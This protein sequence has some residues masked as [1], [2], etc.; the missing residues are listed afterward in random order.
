MWFC[1]LSEHS[2]PNTSW[3]AKNLLSSQT[4]YTACNRN[5]VWHQPTMTHSNN[6]EVAITYLEPRLWYY[7]QLA[8]IE[9]EHNNICTFIIQWGT[10]VLVLINIYPY[11]H[12]NTARGMRA[13]HKLV[14]LL[15]LLDH[16]SSCR[17]FS[18]RVVF[19]TTNPHEP[20]LIFH[21]NP[22]WWL[23]TFWL[24]SKWDSKSS[25]R[26]AKAKFLVQV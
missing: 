3:P 10:P 18:T 19:R 20:L 15:V 8:H 4:C 5:C 11:I 13:K 2:Q 23:C 17:G 21:E 16:K 9:T 26:G 6:S 1:K 24:S 7:Q 25:I 12:T 22:F 14:A